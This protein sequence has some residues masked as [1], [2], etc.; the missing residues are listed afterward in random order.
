MPSPSLTTSEIPM[1]QRKI[2]LCDHRGRNAIVVL[3]PRR[4]ATPLGYRD[5]NGAQVR[6]CRCIKSTTIFDSLLHQHGNSEVLAQALVDGDP[7]LDLEVAGRET[8]AC[9]RVYVDQN[10]KPLYSARMLEVVCDRDGLEIQRRPMEVVSANL[11][12][13]RAPVWSGKLLSR[14]KANGRVAFTRAYQVRHGNALEYD[15]LYGLAAHLEERDSLVLVGSGPR[16]I[17]PLIPERNAYPMKGFLGGQTRGKAYRLVLYMA[18][19][20]LRKPEART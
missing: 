17:G 11:V 9:D 16:G 10:S 1:S 5:A 7:E 20:E 14:R 6:F 2:W 4:H 18:A 19:F 15:F 3:V 8:G 13:E 12:P